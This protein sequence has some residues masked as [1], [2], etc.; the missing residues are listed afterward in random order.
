MASPF[1]TFSPTVTIGFWL[2]QV[3]PLVLLNLR[4]LWV[5]VFPVWYLTVM[6]SPVT[7]WI[8][9]SSSANTKIPESLAA[10]YSIPVPTIGLSVIISGTA[11]RCMLA[12]IKALLASSCSKKGIMAAAIE[13]N[14]FGETSTYC[15]LSLSTSITSFLNLTL[16]RGWTNF[17]F[18]STGSDAW[19][20]I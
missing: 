3:P 20:I 13:T 18:L 10:L 6:A 19:A 8:T 11:W 7:F 14:C 12:P 9:P 17:P 4:S 1:F 15:T 2:I 16:I 5:M